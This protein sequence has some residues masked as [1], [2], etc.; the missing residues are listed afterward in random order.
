MKESNLKVSDF[1]TTKEPI[2]V[3]GVH[4]SYNKNKFNEE[5]VYAKINKIS[6]NKMKLMALKRL[7]NI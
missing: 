5:N 3:L 6:K 1:K 7:H 2:K 4:L